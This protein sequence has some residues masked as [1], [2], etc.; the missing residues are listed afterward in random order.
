MKKYGTIRSRDI[1]E[2][3]CA[4]LG[5]DVTSSIKYGSNLAK[6]EELL[7]T[8]NIKQYPLRQISDI[9]KSK[10]LKATRKQK[11]QLMKNNNRACF[12][13]AVILYKT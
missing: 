6:A 1:F 8:M 3:I 2:D 11:K 13:G 10:C 7:K 9:Y 5:C 4:G 12:T